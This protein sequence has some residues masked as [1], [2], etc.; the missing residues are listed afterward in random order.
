[1]ANVLFVVLA[2]ATYYAVVYLTPT[3]IGGRVGFWFSTAGATYWVVAAVGDA[4]DH[5]WLAV[6]VDLLLCATGLAGV[7][8]WSDNLRTDRAK[9]TTRTD[10]DR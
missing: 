9:R 4:I 1:M 6:A 7:W 8:A 5:R 2:V 3:R 10:A